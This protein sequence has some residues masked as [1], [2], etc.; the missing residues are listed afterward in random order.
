MARLPVIVGF[1]GFNAAGRSSFHHAYRRTI[2]GSLSAEKRISTLLSLAT[3]MKLV[4]YQ[5]GSYIDQNGESL[6]AEQVADKYQAT[7]EQNSLVR[8]IH[9]GL[10]DVDNVPST[11]DVE[12][13]SEQNSEFVLKRRDLPSPIP[14]NWDVSTIDD[15]DGYFRV[16]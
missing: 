2:L 15:T 16:L 14:S 11:R 10:F 9:K 3:V 1:G 13:S 8:R 5:E 12:M 6:T 7:I 4:E